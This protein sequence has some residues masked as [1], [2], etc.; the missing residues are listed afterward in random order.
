MSSGTE[1]WDA[2]QVTEL[3]TRGRELGCVSMSALDRIAEELD[4]GGDDV[5]ALHARLREEDIEVKD[6]CGRDG[7]PDTQVTSR[8]MAGYTTDALQQFLNEARQHPLLSP[9]MVVSLA[10]RIENG[11]Q[12][13]KDRMITSNLRLVISIARKYQGVGELSLLDLIQE[14]TL[15]LIRAVEKFDWRK[16]FRFSTYA[17]LWIRQAISRAVDERGRTIRVPISLAQRERKIAAAERTLATRLGRDPTTAEVAEE[18]GLT[19]EQIEEL[20]DVA[21]KVTS[22][23][24]PAADG[25]ET[26]FGA[27]LPGD[28]PLPE[29]QLE[30]TLREQAVRAVLEQLPE[31]ERDVIRLRYGL[32]GDREP[33]SMR[34]AAERLGLRPTAVQGLERRALEHLATR[35]ELAALQGDR[36]G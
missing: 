5:D 8:E 2:P 18:A 10:K 34:A 15:G 33:L 24:R 1:W 27:L 26:E 3:L 17:T 36:D 23:E 29:E 9:E 16:G 6:D 31:R 11:D 20:S 25:S 14:G 7:T 21:R 4:L 13:A 35:R 28:E 22:L 30:V 32:N 12:A 19:P